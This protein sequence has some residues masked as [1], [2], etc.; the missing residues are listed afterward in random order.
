M[1]AQGID[2]RSGIPGSVASDDADT[3]MVGRIRLVLAV[4]VLLTTVVDASELRAVS[5]FAWLAFSGYVVHSL[6]FY[7]LAQLDNPLAKSSLAPRLD[8]GWYALIVIFTGGTDSVFFLLFFFAILTASFRNGFEEGGRITIASAALFAASALLVEQDRDLPRLLL[9]TTFLLALGYMSAHWGESKVRA[10]QRLALLRDVSRLSNPRF[11]VDQ[12]ITSVLQKIRSHFDSSS[13]ILVMRDDESGIYSVRTVKEGAARQPLTAERIDAEAGSLLMPFVP[14]RVIL[15]RRRS[16][17]LPGI[18]G[19]SLAYDS[20]HGKWIR[21]ESGASENLAELLE[22]QSFISAPLSLRTG[23][24]H[25]YVIAGQR[26]FGKTDAVFLSHIAAHA[27]PVIDS[28][29]LLDRIA[30]DAASQERKKIA[31]NLHDTALQPYIGLKMAL[32]AVRNKAAVDNPLIEDLDRL[33]AMATQVIGDLRRYAGAF[34]NESGQ[35]EPVLIAVLRG[36][37]AKMKEFYGIDI[38]LDIEGTPEVSDRLAAEVL[39]LV[40]EGLSNVRKHTGARHGKISLRCDR[41]QL[42][43]RIENEGSGTPASEFTPRSITERASSLGGEAWVE[44]RADGSTTVQI[45]IPI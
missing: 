28:I 43:I 35:T 4:S 18:K 29:E 23:D 6:V 42:N 38:A 22:A 17:S 32:S 31:W 45:K 10:K 5:G 34:R 37:A 14:D 39:H 30:S 9:R 3:V 21:C 13:C 24:G 1:L 2:T 44:Q 25:I 40:S 19:V 16:S 12:T 26:A 33:T 20:E 8:V 7:I 41:G 15:Y 27:F 36:Q 11:G